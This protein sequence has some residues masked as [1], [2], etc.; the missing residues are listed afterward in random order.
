MNLFRFI[1]G[2]YSLVKI[3]IYIYNVKRKHFPWFYGEE[4]VYEGNKK[5]N[6]ITFS[7]TLG[8]F[9]VK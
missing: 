4:N 3:Y 9:Q 7:L 8:R 1:L 6:P 2:S 5:E